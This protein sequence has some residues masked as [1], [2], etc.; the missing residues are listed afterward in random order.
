LSVNLQRTKHY[1]RSDPGVPVAMGFQVLPVTAATFYI[2][3]S[4]HEAD[5][6]TDYGFYTLIVGKSLQL[7]VTA[8]YRGK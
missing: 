1:F 3:G 2:Y 8:K 6:A 7:P 4:P 5:Q